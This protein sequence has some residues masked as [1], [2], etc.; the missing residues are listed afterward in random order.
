MSRK[1]LNERSRSSLEDQMWNNLVEAIFGSTLST[2]VAPMVAIGG[3]FIPGLPFLGRVAIV[4]LAGLLAYGGWLWS[5]AWYE[6]HGELV[7][8]REA[9]ED[10][11]DAEQEAR[12][13][14]STQPPI[15]YNP[16]KWTGA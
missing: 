14:R 4:A 15:I 12:R 11:K 13:P 16:S 5:R 3:I 1:P 2:V 8:R 10:R 7:R 9:R 6:A